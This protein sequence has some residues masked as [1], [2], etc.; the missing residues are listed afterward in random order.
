MRSN[1]L[2][3]VS[4]NPGA[5]QVCTEPSDGRSGML[6]T[7]QKVKILSSATTLEDAAKAFRVEAEEMASSAQ[8][9]EILATAALLNYLASRM[10]EAIRKG[11]PG[12]GMRDEEVRASWGPPIRINRSVGSWGVHEQWV[13]PGRNYLYFKNGSLTS[14]QRSKRP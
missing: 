14:I 5:V 6:V 2:T 1:T 8:E 10:R 4:N 7:K 3:R 13:Y 11:R 9:A 12:L